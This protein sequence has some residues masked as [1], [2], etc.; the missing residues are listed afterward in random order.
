MDYKS[1]KFYYNRNSNQLFKFF[2]I[3][4][5][6]LMGISMTIFGVVSKISFEK[7]NK[8]YIETIAEIVDSVSKSESNKDKATGMISRYYVY[9]PVIKYKIEGEEIRT[10]SNEYSI[11]QPNIGE[12][13]EIK[14]NPN[15]PNDFILKEDNY[16][17]VISIIG[18]ILIII[19]I[20]LTFISYK[21]RPK[22]KKIEI[23]KE[24]EIT[25]KKEE[26]TK[27]IE[28]K[29]N[30]LLQEEIETLEEEIEEDIDNV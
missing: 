22:K 17:M 3:I 14:Y 30:E 25:E 2:L 16:G 8:G 11:S 19:G 26:L 18:S 28:K 12:K 7:R 23:L 27:F 4:T 10:E 24:K 21:F 13:I 20:T 1:E 5:L 29:E 6:I 15:N 9:A